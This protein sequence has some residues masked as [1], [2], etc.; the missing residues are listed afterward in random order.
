M[1]TKNP[2]QKRNELIAA[3]KKELLAFGYLPGIVDKAMIW[4]EQCAEGMIGYAHRQ[5]FEGG[6]SSKKTEL[7]NEFLPQYLADCEK[8]IQSFGHNRGEM[9]PQRK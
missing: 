9:K 2:S 3:K 6:D 7:A 4:A 5:G 8:Y 1:P